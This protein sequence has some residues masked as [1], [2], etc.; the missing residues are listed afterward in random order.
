MHALAGAALILGAI[1][2]AHIARRIEK[3]EKGAVLINRTEY[4]AELQSVCSET[5]SE[6]ERYFGSTSTFD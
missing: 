5:I 6:I 2:L 4:L 1:R 3:A